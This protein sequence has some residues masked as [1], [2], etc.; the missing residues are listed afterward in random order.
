MPRSVLLAQPARISP[1]WPG[2]CEDAR[3]EP[4]AAWAPGVLFSGERAD[5]ERS[6]RGLKNAPTPAPW[7]GPTREIQG[8]KW[9]GSS[10]PIYF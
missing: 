6:L 2:G 1:F 5:F 7:R 8:T 3:V 4:V 9:E 10:G